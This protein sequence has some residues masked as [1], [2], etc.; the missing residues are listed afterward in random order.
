MIH[1]LIFKEDS[2]SN[3]S[4]KMGGTSS[5]PGEYGAATKA[6]DVAKE[7]H[8]KCNGKFVIVTGLVN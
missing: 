8:D 3:L 5:K 7:F 1:E 2:R 4:V 6:E